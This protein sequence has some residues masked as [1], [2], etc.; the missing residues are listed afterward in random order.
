M[1]LFRLYTLTA[2]LLSLLCINLQ[3]QTM[4]D[5]PGA[6]AAGVGA[7]NVTISNAWAVQNN[8]GALA[9]IEAPQLAFGFNTRLQLQELTTFGALAAYPLSNGAVGAS[10]S[11]YGT[12]PYSIQDYGLGYSHKISY[13]SLGI[14]VSY[15]QQS[16]EQVGSQG[17][18]VLEAGG[19]AELLPGL[20]F[21]A[22]AYNLSQ[23]RFTRRNEERIPTLLKAGLSYL[24]TNKLRLH[25][26]TAKNIDYPARFSAGIEYA[27]IPQLQ[28]RSGIQTQPLDA[29]F[30]LGIRLRRVLFDYAF[31]H[32]TDLGVQHHLSVGYLLQKEKQP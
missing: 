30:G 9:F 26:Q 11:R 10:F 14:K 27:L 3:G 22:Y 6:K 7:A 25:V 13:I 8:I 20:H 15:L 31:S 5:F 32:Q 19:K 12:G 21:A 16:I 24:P 17:S 28:L 29:S 4:P 23:S 1:Q 18:A 2:L